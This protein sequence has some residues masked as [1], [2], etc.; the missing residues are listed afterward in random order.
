MQRFTETIM[1]GECEVFYELP[2]AFI[3]IAI[4]R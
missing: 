1:T 4:I 2:T 3:I